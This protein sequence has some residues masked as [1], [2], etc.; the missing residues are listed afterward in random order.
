M[1]ASGVTVT[2][3]MHYTEAAELAAVL[4]DLRGTYPIVHKAW[5][6]LC[7]AGVDTQRGT[8]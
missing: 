2:L 7:R 5:E 4:W 1:R 6:A 8:S 3:E